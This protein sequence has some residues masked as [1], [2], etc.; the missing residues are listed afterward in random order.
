[1]KTTIQQACVEAPGQ[2]SGA[3]DPGCCCCWGWW[4]SP[5]AAAPRARRAAGD[6]TT[7]RVG[8]LLEPD[9]LNPFI[10]LLGQDYEI[11]HLN[12]DFLV[13]FDAKDLSPKPE[14]AESW[15]VSPDGKT[16]TFKIRQGVKWQDG[17]PLTAKDVAFTYNYIVKNDL[18]TLAIYTGGITGAVATD[19]YTVDIT[20]EKPKSN[21][22]AMVVP[23]I[24]EH[25]WSKVSGKAA[26]TTLPEQAADHRL[27][28]L[29][30]RGV[31]PGQVHPH[32][33]Q[34]GLLGRQ[35]QGRRALLRELQERRHHDRRPQAGR[36]RRGG[37]AAAGAVPVGRRAPRG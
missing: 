6:A 17:E 21:M 32:G 37:R 22:L 31:E 20:T 5:V 8:W 7:F 27:R 1:M 35:A 23:I 12:Y 16:W 26:T 25:I 30:D 4:P 19:D 2:R 11:W 36:H 18:Q 14:L 3:P 13:G 34:Q 24:P 10:G 9:N 15:T 28:S 33:R 29:P